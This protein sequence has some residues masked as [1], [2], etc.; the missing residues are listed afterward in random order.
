MLLTKRCTQVLDII[1]HFFHRRPHF[2][3]GNMAP[4]YCFTGDYN[5]TALTAS[6]KYQESF[7]AFTIFDQLRSCSCR[8][9]QIHGNK[10]TG[11]SRQLLPHLRM[12]LVV[13]MFFRQP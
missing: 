5:Q 4:M 9:K 12:H 3:S 1:A 8:F 11:G 2:L 13:Q 7:S 10:R 6:S